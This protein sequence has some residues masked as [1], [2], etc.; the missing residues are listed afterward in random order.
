MCCWRRL[1]RDAV[2][3]VDARRGVR[4]AS[5]C[6][7]E[8]PGI[9]RSRELAADTSDVW[10]QRLVC[11]A[12]W[13][14]GGSGGPYAALREAIF[15]HP[16]MAEPWRDVDPLLADKN[17]ATTRHLLHHLSAQHNTW[18]LVVLART[19]NPLTRRLDTNSVDFH[20]QQDKAA[21]TSDTREHH[22]QPAQVYLLVLLVR[23]HHT[24][25]GSE[26]KI[27][28]CYSVSEQGGPVEGDGAVGAAAG[29]SYDARYSWRE[30]GE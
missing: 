27:T 14:W 30:I 18:S 10:R 20:S 1:L 15:A 12:A 11:P 29:T 9:E 5:G 21:P 28:W 4:S 3:Y 8:S 23:P 16:H 7:T 6:W 26:G 24:L 25:A 13:R 22:L 2:R 17:A 19:F